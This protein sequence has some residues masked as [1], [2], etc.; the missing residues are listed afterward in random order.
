[1]TFTVPS[2]MARRLALAL[3][4]LALAAACSSSPTPGPPV[5]LPSMPAAT[6]TPVTY[7][8]ARP[9]IE[10]RCVVCHGCYDAPCQLLLSSGEGLERGASTAV[11]YDGGRLTEV[12]PTRLFIDAHGP[13]AWRQRGFF[14]VDGAEPG[15]PS[16]L[17]L[18]LALGRAN[19]FPANDTP[20]GRGGPRHQPR[21]LLPDAAGV[22][23][24]CAGAPLGRHAV[25]HGTAWRRRATPRWCSGSRRGHRD[26][27]RRR[28]SPKTADHARRPLGSA[29]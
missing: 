18:M 22:R 20:A 24:L 27:P 10:R 7:R 15:T 19:T 3:A 28:H 2:K 12:P 1:M 6:G 21:A 9:I 4:P 25:R 8:D 13:A 23:H 29:S 26:R 16:L 14:P 11:V 5:V 17:F